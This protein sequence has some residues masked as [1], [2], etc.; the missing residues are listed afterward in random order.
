MSLFA[1][2]TALLLEQLKPLWQ[3]K[4]LHGWSASYVEYFQHH[5]NSGEYNHGRTAWWLAVLPMV[6]GAAL[7][8]RGLYYLHPM[9]AWAFN[10]GVLYL[11]M[12]FRQYSHGFADIRLAL[13][14]RELERAREVLSGLRG[15]A[16]G[17]LNA[18]QIT[19]ITVE[20]SLIA[21]LHHLFG[22][23]VWF[24]AFSLLGLGGAAGALLYSLGLAL[25]THWLGE[26]HAGESVEAK[27]DG[28]ARKM[29]ARLEW[30]PIRLTAATFAIVGNFEDTVYCWRSQAP[31]W[32]D[33]EMGILLASAAG[34]SGARLGLPVLQDGELLERPE[35]GVGDKAGDAALHGAV[36]LMW[37]SSVLMMVVL[38]MLTLAG[39]LG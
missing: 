24:V 8:F 32:P 5:F 29:C 30:L 11:T 9:L 7:V 26:L 17:E 16:S 21:A 1:L 20:T 33:G 19:R 25:N 15:G 23:V 27:F 35:L 6:L 22:V 12:G 36:R 39:L 18:E 10:V 4:H 2:I 38:F 28:F 13:N 14:S 34:A 37:R 3:R 31:I